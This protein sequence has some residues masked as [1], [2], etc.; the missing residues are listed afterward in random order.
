MMTPSTDYDRAKGEEEHILELPGGRQL[1]YAHNGPETSRTIAL[2]FTGLFAVGNAAD[3]P[4][5]CRELEMHC[6]HPSLP[7]FGKYSSRDLTEPYHVG[8]AR[9]MCALL[10]HLYPTSAFD[11]I[12]LLGGS[13]GTVQAQM[14][15]GAPYKL[16][17]PGRQI[18]GC[19]LIAGLSPFYYD[20][21]YAKT[22]NWQNWFS[23]GPPSQFPLRPLQRLVRKIIASKLETLHGARAFLRSTIF[24]HMDDDEKEM[25]AQWLSKKEKTEEEFVDQ[26][27]KGAIRCCDNWDGFMEA[28]DVL[29]SEWGFEPKALEDDH[30]S[31]PV[32]VVGSEKDHLGS[33]TNGWVVENYR[34]AKLKVFRGGHISSIYYMDDIW[35]E[36]I[37]GMCRKG[38]HFLKI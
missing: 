23:V 3:V 34:G 28:S 31:K 15:Y 4:T 18:V 2:C 14:L 21:G 36:M 9:D 33:S 24:S 26:M 1:A 5:P 16:F 10:L 32:L 20:K 35:Q 13:Y 11:A 19:I 17:P 6:I 27:A 25:F 22:L 30:A 12:Y 7:G 37:D 8:L 38:L 29:H